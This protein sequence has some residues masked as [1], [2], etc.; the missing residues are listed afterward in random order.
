MLALTELRRLA[1]AITLMVGVGASSLA[2]GEP[3][4][5]PPACDRPRILNLRYDED[6]TFLRDPACRTDLWDPLKYIPLSRRLEVYLTL[7]G[8]VRA[9]YDYIHNQSWGRGPDDGYLLSR[10]MAFG[11]LHLG[12]HARVF[13]ELASQFVDGRKGGPGPVDED[14]LDLH[15]GFVDLA[16]EIPE[17]GPFTLRAGRQEVDYASARLISAREGAN[18]R[19]SFEGLRAIQRVRAWEIDAL[20]LAPVATNPGVFDDGR[21]PGQRL[22][23]IYAFGPVISEAFALD[24]YYL[25]LLRAEATFEQ[26]TARERRHTI[27]TRLS[28][29]PAGLDYNFEL[30]YQLGSF[31][32]GD[33]RAWTVASDTGYTFESVRW[34]VRIGA[35]VNVTSGDGDP[36]DPDLQTFNP[37]FPRA[38]YFSEAGLIGPL[39]HMDVHPVVALEVTEQLGVS[40]AWDG[41]WRQSLDDGLYTTAGGLQV[42]GVGNPARHVGSELSLTLLWTTRHASVLASYVHFFAGPFL[43]RA[44]LDH[45]V[46]Y[47]TVW[48]KYQL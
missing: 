34:P 45:D 30:V 16:V 41:F 40:V 15:Q 42:P 28:G 17:V 4:D 27:G 33:I 39:N 21:V 36:L 19:L 7:G 1:T 47:A 5:E 23:G 11:D 13:A 44:G 10:F 2:S 35:Q 22:W 48:V 43:R 37:L 24:V 32:A 14:V 20:A 25:G 6:W 26:G 29:E 12:P 18:V 8:Q 3:A 38:S 31:G 46:D 9:R